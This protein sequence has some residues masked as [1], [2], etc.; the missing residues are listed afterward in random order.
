MAR[1]SAAVQIEDS[2]GGVHIGQ[3]DTGGD[4]GSGAGPI[5]KERPKRDAEILGF[6]TFREPI[7][8][9]PATTIDLVP[10]APV[11]GADPPQAGDGCRRTA[12][13]HGRLGQ[14]APGDS[15]VS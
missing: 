5:P 2:E 3:S 8:D 14:R 9:E 6:G 11:D 1:A 10:P 13:G 12:A 15:S 7:S 4:L